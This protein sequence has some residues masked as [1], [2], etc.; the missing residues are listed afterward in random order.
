M[1]PTDD[2]RD[3]RAEHAQ[4]PEQAQ[5]RETPE[6]GLI[7]DDELPEDL[8][9]TEDNPLAQ[10]PAESDTSGDGPGKDGNTKVEGMPDVGSPGAPG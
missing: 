5:Q 9:P 7:G 8:Q 10:D 6:V 3:D 2:G 4:D 1:T